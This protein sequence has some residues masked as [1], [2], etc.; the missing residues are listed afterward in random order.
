MIVKTLLLCLVLAAIYAAAEA[1]R[2]TSSYVVISLA[3]AEAGAEHA[4]NPRR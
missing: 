4:A 1:A 3:S 2:S